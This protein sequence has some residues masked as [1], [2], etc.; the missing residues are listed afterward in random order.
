MSHV[1]R[2]RPLGPLTTSCECLSRRYGTGKR[3]AS[4]RRRRLPP[5]DPAWRADTQK[6]LAFPLQVRTLHSPE[7][8][9]PWRW[10]VSAARITRQRTARSRRRHTTSTSQGKPHTGRPLPACVHSG[11]SLC[12]RVMHPSGQ[13]GLQDEAAQDVG[14]VTLS[15]ALL[16]CHSADSRHAR[17]LL[18]GGR[19]GIHSGQG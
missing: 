12:F 3:A 15:S 7:R 8:T 19:H 18:A 13:L 17:S 2:K 10:W 6:R 4:P 9:Q 1:S 11:G 16:S 14:E 5:A